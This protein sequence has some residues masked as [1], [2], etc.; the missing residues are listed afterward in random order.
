MNHGRATGLWHLAKGLIRLFKEQKPDIVHVQYLAPGFVPVV[1]AW[2]AGVKTIFATVH[3]PGRTYG[4]KEKLLLRMAARFCSAFFCVSKAAEKSWFGDSAIF[5]PGA[6]KFKRKHFTI[7]NAVDLTTIDNIVR[8]SDRDEIK[9]SLNISGRKIIGVVGR[10]RFEKGQKVLL[11]AMSAVIRKCPDAMLLVVGG[12]PD[13]EDLKMTAE[14]LDIQDYIIWLGMKTP[15]EVW[16]L[17]SIM[18]IVAVPSFFEGF[19]L[20]AAEAM[21]VGKPVV[22]SKVD[23]LCEVIEDGVTGY[24]VPGN[25]EQAL[26]G[27]LIQLLNNPALAKSMGENGRDRVSR[28]FSM[29]RF[30]DSIRAIYNHFS[31]I[32]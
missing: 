14:R 20:V 2:I 16:Q 25:D 29:E 4:L 17:Y 19:G 3:Q 27:V 6:I 18:D 10:L 13:L 21:A 26:A 1:A 32:A 9:C 5:D 30:S 23:G 24:L 11:H 12:G 22:V 28:L 15:D 7:Y 31:R 8:S